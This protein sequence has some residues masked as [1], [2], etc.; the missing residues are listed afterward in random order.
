MGDLPFQSRFMKSLSVDL[1]G[2]DRA[3]KWLQSILDCD[4]SSARR[5]FICY[6]K[7]GL[8]EM[9]LVLKE[10]PSVLGPTIKH[11]M[12]ANAMLVHYSSFRNIEEVDLYLKSIINRFEQALVQ[13]AELK[14]V[15]RDLPLFYFLSDRRLAEFKISLWANH[16]PG[17]GLMHLSIDTYALC[18]EVYRLYRELN[19]VEIWNRHVLLNQF[20]MIDWYCRYRKIDEG[21]TTELY[22]AMEQRIEEYKNWSKLG[23]K[24]EKGKLNL[25]FTDFITMNNGGML[26]S[27]N[28]KT[29]MTAVSNV[30]FVSFQGGQPCENFKAEF[31]L[32]RAYA[33]SVSRNNALAR[34][35]IFDQ[36]LTELKGI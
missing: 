27:K 26:E 9:A 31:D 8:E 20:N 13:K 1:G 12:P 7:L 29:L 17:S 28:S 34:E 19:S 36:I 14:Y 15:A 11:L 21:Y 23:K 3:V 30:N 32:H 2:D 35:E 6:T 33:T 22:Q 18:M 10:A 24:D 5:K 25:L 16:L 4:Y